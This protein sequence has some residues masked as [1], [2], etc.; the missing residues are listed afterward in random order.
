MKTLL[1]LFDYTG[2]WAR[3]FAES[4]WNVIL[5][6]I[7]HTT[8][9]YSTFSDIQYACADYFHE[10]IFDNYGTVDGIIAALPCTDFA[11]S[12]ARWWKEKDASGQT[13]ESIELAYQTLRIIDLCK[14]DFWAVENPVG[15]LHKLVP[16]MGK[17]LMYFQPCDYGDPYTKKTALY[18]DFNTDLERNP[19]FPSEG[20][21]MHR[22]YG[23]KSAKTK[24]MRSITPEGFSKAFFQANRDYV[25]PNREW[26]DEYWEE[27]KCE[28]LQLF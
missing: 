24:E 5:W 1:S 11:G 20:S 7:K 16:E 4:G 2:N 12:G 28:Q 10:N 25:T 26:E 19:V 21:K 3:P 9:L 8:D 27:I 14:P 18:G 22:M 13:A 15:R 17:P 23:G 6:D